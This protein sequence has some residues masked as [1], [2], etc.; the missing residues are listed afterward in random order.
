MYAQLRFVVC[1]C[2][3]AGEGLQLMKVQRRRG[4]YGVYSLVSN[5]HVHSIISGE[6]LPLQVKVTPRTQ[7][8]C[9]APTSH[10]FFVY[11]LLLLYIY[12]PSL[13]SDN[14][15]IFVREQVE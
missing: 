10:S 6:L 2:A 15:R 5:L 8:A 3:R 7:I 1:I 11:Y 14:P 9:A 13:S 12:Y 4:L